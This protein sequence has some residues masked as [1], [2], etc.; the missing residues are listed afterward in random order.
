MQ[1]LNR[2]NI[3]GYINLLILENE[4]AFTLSVIGISN[5]VGRILTGLLAD[6]PW[7]NA[8]TL[9]SLSLILSS[10]CVFL[11]PFVTTYTVFIILSSVF[12]LFVSAYISLTSIMLVDLVG[13]DQLTSSFGLVTMFRGGSAMLGPPLAGAVFEAT[14]SFMYSFIM[15]AGFFLAAGIFSFAADLLRRREINQT[16][17]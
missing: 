5:T 7:S 8:L 10:V 13:I 11:F 4:A 12:G 9:T 2:F 1:K 15:A 16:I 17:E 14:S 6:Q 3:T